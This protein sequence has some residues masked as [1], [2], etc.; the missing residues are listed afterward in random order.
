MT[1]SYK[2]RSIGLKAVHAYN[3]MKMQIEKITQSISKGN[4]NVRG[5]DLKFEYDFIFQLR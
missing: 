1:Y 5:Q 4:H 2:V 3:Y